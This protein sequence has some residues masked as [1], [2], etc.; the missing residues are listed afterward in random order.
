MEGHRDAFLRSWVTKH[1]VM[2]NH[3]CQI[4]Y[5]MRRPK[6][7]PL[8]SN[9]GLYA[10]YNALRRVVYPRSILV[11]RGQLELKPIAAS[12]LPSKRRYR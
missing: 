6:P 4:K 5:L 3:C 7:K 10:L 8:A 11:F 12:R 1:L 2:H 9:D